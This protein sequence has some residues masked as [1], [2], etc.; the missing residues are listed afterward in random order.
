MPNSS[1]IRPEVGATVERH[2]RPISAANRSTVN[3]VA[4][5]T[6]NSANAAAR[7]A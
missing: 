1:V 5:S 6:T 2:S 4:G 3:G 7:D